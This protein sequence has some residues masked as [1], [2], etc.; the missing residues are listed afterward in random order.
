MVAR[1]TSTAEFES[2]QYAICVPGVMVSFCPATAEVTVQFR[3]ARSSL[4]K[5]QIQFA[6]FKAIHSV[7]GV[8]VAPLPVMQDVRGSIPEACI[9]HTL[10]NIMSLLNYCTSRSFI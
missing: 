3:E 9:L 7:S 8:M 4:F 1:R 5:Y 6:L 2:I 10:T